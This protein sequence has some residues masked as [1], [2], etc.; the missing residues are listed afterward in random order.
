MT[1]LLKISLVSAALIAGIAAILISRKSAPVVA[2]PA[3]KPALTVT[4]THASQSTWPVTFRADGNIAAWQEA[5]IGSET[6]GMKLASVNVNVGDQVK[7]GQVLAQFSDDTLLADLAVQRANQAE[8]IAASTEASANAERALA[9]NGSGAISLQQIAQ[10]KTAALT[11][12]ARLQAANAQLNR[13]Q[14]N[15]RKARIVAPD[16][17]VISARTATVG[18]VIQA[19]QPLFSLIRKNKLEWRAELTAEQ[20]A[21][22]RPGLAVNITLPGNQLIAGKVRIA[23]PSLNVQTRTGIVYVDIPSNAAA[24]AGMFVQGVFQLG[25]TVGMSLPAT[26]TTT[27][28]G[29]NYVYRLSA[30]SHAVLTR[31]NVGQRANNRVEIIN[32]IRMT[33]TIITDGVGF[34]NDGDLVR[35]ATNG[36]LK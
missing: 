30:D 2:A 1:K 13:L 36:T 29:V 3:A 25:S 9:L 24:R 11:A 27:R 21:R 4:A 33:D 6:G 17:G 20:L 10:A 12:K 5:S 8:A 22:I 14:L 16:D 7:R 26:A 19:G 18:A 15:V 28:D 32:G 23:A 31:V 34:L 35:V